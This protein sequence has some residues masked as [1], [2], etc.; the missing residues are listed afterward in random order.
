[1]TDA[2]P[3]ET[4]LV[5][6]DGLVAWITVNRPKKLNALS[7]RLLGELDHAVTSLC[8]EAPGAVRACVI[9]GSGSKAFVAGADIGE[10]G[11]LDAEAAR[12]F[13]AL[14]QSVFQRLEDAPFPVIAAVN[15]FALG[16][17]CELALSC[18]IVLAGESAK[19]GQPEVDLGLMPGFGGCFRLIER[20]G[21]GQG[22]LWLF[23]GEHKG[24]RDAHAIGLVDRV[25]P[26]TELLS[27]TRELARRI[28]DKAPLAI[29]AIKRTSRRAARLDRA[30]AAALESEAFGA[31]F[32][33]D[34]AREGIS[35]FLE[36]RAPTFQKGRNADDTRTS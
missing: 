32:A 2:T 23:T 6:R 28:A 20:I 17:G 33:S 8:G 14:G 19:F 35:A 22:R 15:G 26:D 31:L 12:A 27:E 18:D 34:D 21:P 29:A 30:S 5:E 13:S 16:G 4:L 24:A 7:R 1:M 10:M 3:Y 36:Q 25:F 11:S 9:T